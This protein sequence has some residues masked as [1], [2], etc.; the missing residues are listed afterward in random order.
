MRLIEFIY[1]DYMKAISQQKEV[2]GQFPEF[3]VSEDEIEGILEM[4]NKVSPSEFE[5]NEKIEV[6]NVYEYYDESF[7]IFFTILD[8]DEDLYISL[9]MTPYWEMAS[10]KA[11]IVNFEHLLSNKFAIL[12][13][14]LNLNSNFI[15][16][17]TYIG[18]LQ[19]EDIEILT[20]FYN[21]EI[22]ELPE[23][24]RGFSYPEGEGFYQEE[25]LKNEIERTFKLNIF[26][27]S[28]EF[29]EEET[30]MEALR[31]LY[32]EETEESPKDRRDLFYPERESFYQEG[33]FKIPISPELLKNQPLAAASEEKTVYRGS[34]F[35]LFYNKENNVIK[36]KP[37]EEIVN[38]HAVLIVFNKK[39]DY[40]I[41]NPLPR[42]IEIIIP[43]GI[44]ANIDYI[45]QNIRIE[46]V[47]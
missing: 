23:D 45:G 34:N 25:F 37:D 43:E 42:V 40:F 7:P 11:L 41:K 36:L 1:K 33:F 24:R 28:P 10:D 44:N 3:K 6:G 27:Q 18:K 38:K 9:V 8:T 22:Q 32:D 12:P 29:W 47:K 2:E 13:I 20:K 14:I 39:Y 19:R 30:I 46:E 4:L 21:G 26:A 16:K 31:K 35:R 15:K 5:K 17:A